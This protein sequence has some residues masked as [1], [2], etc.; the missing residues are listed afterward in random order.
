MALDENIGNKHAGDP[1]R[2]ADWNTLAAETRR[3]GMALGVQVLH[4]TEDTWNFSTDKQ[5]Y[6]PAIERQVTFDSDASILVVGHCS[7]VTNPDSGLQMVLS[8]DGEQLHQV[9]KNSALS[10]GM[11]THWG[12]TRGEVSTP[13]VTIGMHSVKAGAHTLQLLARSTTPGQSVGVTGAT[14]FILRVGAG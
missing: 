4:G 5:T 1:I 2:S 13:L 3:L 10:W 14:L 6:E 7:A 8:V 12:K 11:A 9:N